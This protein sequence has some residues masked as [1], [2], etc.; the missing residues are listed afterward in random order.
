MSLEFE[1]VSIAFTQGLDTRTQRKLVVAGKW[2][3]LLNFSLSKDNTPKL[4][5]GH[6]AL[7]A[8]ANGNGLATYNKELLTLSGGYVYSVST[9]EASVKKMQGTRGYV[10]VKKTELRRGPY[11]QDTPDCACGNGLLCYVW[12][13]CDAVSAPVSVNVKLVDEATGAEVIANTAMQLGMDSPRVVFSG[14][15]FFIFYADVAGILYCRI[16]N[17]L[18]GAPTLGAQTTLINSANYKYRWFDSIPWMAG[19]PEAQIVYGW[20]DGVTSVRTATVN[21]VA[22]APALNLGPTNVFSQVDVPLGSLQAVTACAFS[23]NTAAAIFAVSS[24]AGPLCGLAGAVVDATLAI[25]TAAAQLNPNVSATNA[26]CHVTACIDNNGLTGVRVFWDH[27]SEW[28]VAGNLRLWTVQVTAALAVG[29]TTSMVSASFGVGLNARGPQGPFIAGKCFN[30]SGAIFCPVFVA[31]NYPNIASASSNPRNANTQ[32]T[33]FLLEAKG[34]ELNVVAKALYGSYGMAAPSGAPQVR[35]PCSTVLTSSG[36]YTQVVTERTSLALVLGINRS[37]TGLVRLDLTPNATLPAIR[38]QLGESTYFAGGSL[39]TYDGAQ[40][41]EHGFPLYPEGVAVTVNGAATGS[42]TAGVHQ[43]VFIYEWID[44]AGQRHQSAPSLPTTVTVVA[45]GSLT[46]QVPTLLLSNK[47]G[48]PSGNASDINVVAYMTQAGG[49][50][51]YRVALN[52]G[53][54]APVFNSVAAVFVTLTI[55]DSDATIGANEILYTQPNQSPTALA[56]IA[57]PPCNVLCVAQNRLFFDIADQPCQFGFSQEYV[58]NVGLQFSPDLV[59]SIPSDSGGIT[60]ICEMDEK[61]IIFSTG[62]IFVMYGTGPNSS[63][64][65][66]NYSKPQDIQAD[67]GCSEPR[68]ILTGFPGGIIFKSKK[69]FYVLQRD[70]SVKYI[71]EGVALF[72]SNPVTAAVLLADRQEIRFVVSGSNS[73]SGGTF[74]GYTLVYSYLVDQWSYYCKTNTTRYLPVDAM[75]WPAAGGGAGRYVTIS[76]SDGLNQDTPGVYIDQPGVQAAAGISTRARTGWI[77]ISKLE[78]FQRIR[79][80]YLTATADVA[81]TSILT[82]YVAFDDDYSQT[83]SGAYPVFV[84]NSSVFSTWI[85]GPIDLRHKL[86]RQ[87]CKSIAFTFSEFSFPDGT[88]STGIQGLALEVGVKKGVKRLPAAQSVG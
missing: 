46:C 27:I 44:N 37:P 80:L 77:H 50:V 15:V 11:V 74:S 31:S 43:V 33:Y 64:G 71:G 53:T 59:A 47:G 36:V 73:T 8:T 41:T 67:V 54:Y 16:I 40:V 51:F 52:N 10:G 32:N 70:L 28:D 72:D 19:S 24:G 58:N 21:V 83:G 49:L 17:T 1:T 35:T 6:A 57:P 30:A 86:R 45:T 60:G 2:D 61:I 26:D 3:D 78:G 81:P 39:S 29:A 25:A 9:A 66:S 69:G 79:W 7:V 82:I 63:G 76:L 38:T 14:G 68:S 75:W 56:N 62:R 4:R 34:G 42:M 13:E 88:R 55:D 23:T 12:V 22:G 18:S 85:S 5:D 65:F 48:P 87:K 20:F 84:F